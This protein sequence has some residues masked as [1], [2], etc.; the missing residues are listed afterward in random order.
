MTFSIS[1]KE[2][3]WVFVWASLILLL[4]CVPYIIATLTAPPGWQ[5]AGILVN[6]L[7]GQSYMAKMQ[8][9]EAGRWLFH[10]TYTPEP[11]DGSFIFTFYILLGH[12]AAL[13]GLPKILIFHLARL[14]TGLMLLSMA[15]RFIARV[16][17][18]LTERRLAFIFM[19]YSAGLGWL[20]AILGAFPIDLWVPEAFVFYSLY[21]NP[22]FPLAL[23][24]MLL[25]FDQILAVSDVN[26]SPTPA[27]LLL[28]GF[29]ALTLAFILPFALLTVWMVLTVFVAWRYI[30]HRRL[31]WPQIWLTLGVVL[32]SAPM[33]FYQYWVST[34]NPIL[35]GW[36]AQNLTPSPTLLNLGLG[37]GLVGL[38]AII[39]AGRIIAWSRQVSTE[40]EWLVL[41]W[42]ITILALIYIPFDLQ[43]RLINGLYI[44]VCILAAMGLNRWLTASKF[45]AK[46]RQWFVTGALI[47]GILGALFVWILPLLGTMQSPTQSDISALFFIREEEQSAFSWLRSRVE[48]DDVILASP[49]VGMFIPGQT[50]ART[51]YGHPFETIEAETKKA[52]VEAFYRGELKTLLP[53][54]DFIVYGPAEQKLGQPDILSTLT[55]VYEADGVI[56]YQTR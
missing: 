35:A 22:H 11:H 41:L 19:A 1:A 3:G 16:T 27:T 47:S 17:P 9:G 50:G 8:Q 4:S 20:G 36:G 46:S 55:P 51:F 43:R 38:L 42:A 44:P 34:T 14:L 29:A 56:I 31:P 21:A 24:L 12:L 15:Y 5:F 30:N 54:P 40:G 37:L 18:Q 7:D 28:S 45:T 49:R 2:W 52:Q 23:M 53:A 26:F 25:I 13:T 33:I 39:G 48:A 10:L 6:P 32:F